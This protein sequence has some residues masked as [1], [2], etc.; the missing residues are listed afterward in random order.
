MSQLA[1]RFTVFI[2]NIFIAVL[3]ILAIVGHFFSP[4]WSLDLSLRLTSEQLE[5]LLQSGSSQ[6]NS[7]DT[8]VLELLGE[9]GVSLTLAVRLQTKDALG[10]FSANGEQI[11]QTLLMETLT[12]VLSQASE[13]LIAVVENNLQS[14]MNTLLKTELEDALVEIYAE[15]KTQEE[16]Q[17]L[18]VNAGV[19]EAY[20]LEKAGTILDGISLEGATVSSVTD[21]ALDVIEDAFGKVASV[22][23]QISGALSAEI[24]ETIRQAVNEP[25]SQ[26]ADEDG[27]LDIKAQMQDMLWAKIRGDKENGTEGDNL[28]TMEQGLLLGLKAVAYLLI[29]TFVTWAWLL[30][31]MLLK[32][33]ARNNAMKLKLPIWLG[34]LP[35]LI[36]SLLPKAVTTL[37]KNPPAALLSS[38]GE[39]AATFETLAS[40]IELTSASSAWIAFAAAIVLI[41]FSIFFYAPLR[42]KLKREKNFVNDDYDDI[43]E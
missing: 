25:L 2:C 8:D 21:T 14:T 4:L 24:K 26:L 16:I 32:L 36:F 5:P 34:W 20:L 13:T 43:D 10:A 15:T 1:K 40:A 12:S 9:E 42:R 18:L 11:A 27:N 38:L 17:T 28:K 7:S 3:S 33:G 22:D 37:L 31:K 39:Q 6:E 35:F 30:L 41:V 19:T 29:F 23:T